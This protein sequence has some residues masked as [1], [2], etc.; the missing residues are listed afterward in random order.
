M[1][2]VENV[3]K[4]FKDVRA[5]QEV[6]LNVG[7]GEYVALLGP[8]GAGKTTLVEM[9]EGLRTP[10]SGSI[11][12]LGK[13]WKH[14]ERWLRGIMGISLQET[15]FIDKLTVREIMDLFAGFYG[16]GTGEIPD[17]L[18]HIGLLEKSGSY[19]MNLSHGQRQKL[20]LGIALINHPQL[21]ILDEPTTGLDPNA[22]R[23]LWNI[24]GDLRSNGTS[25]ILTTHYMEEA[26]YLCERIIIMN[27]GRIL[28]EGTLEDL[29]RMH[30]AREIISFALEGCGKKSGGDGAAG[31]DRPV[32]PGKT[33]GTGA[34]VGARKTALPGKTDVN[35]DIPDSV[36]RIRGALELVRD[37][38][39]GSGQLYVN[40]IVS[41]LPLFLAAVEREGLRLKRL[42]CR[43]M[44]L[45][46]LFVSL[47]GRRL[48]A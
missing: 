36:A 5:V 34:G 46:D 20:A 10:D 12:I 7:G 9:I 13:T 28:A 38:E 29:L 44:N 6:S 47:T 16:R 37:D 19:S 25:L 11:S 42:E 48:D 33:S 27:Q 14:D 35:C 21:L 26:E 8:N 22:R 45:D 23:E 1:I 17:I 32:P 3:S 43:K 4:S 30:G 41:A 18:E 15:R 2:V 39:P 40:D 24:L 31:A